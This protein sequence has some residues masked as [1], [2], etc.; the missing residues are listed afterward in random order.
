MASSRELISKRNKYYALRDDVN[1][2]LSQTLKTYSSLTNADK[3]KDAF[4]IDGESA[5][6]GEISDI[7]ADIGNVNDKLKNVVIPEINNKIDSLSRQIEQAL[8][9]EEQERRR[10]EEERRQREQKN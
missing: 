1:N 2:I 5:D 4:T 9:R 3:L 7:R 6:N 10:E 8:A